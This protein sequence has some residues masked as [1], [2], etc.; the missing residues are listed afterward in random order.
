MTHAPL[1]TIALSRLFELAARALHSAGHAQGLYPAQWTA[2]RYLADAEPS[3]RT[4]SALARFQQIAIGPV[5]RTVRTLIAKGY[6]VKAGPAGHHR[7][8]RLDLTEAGYALLP[9]DPLRQI[10]TA[11]EALT[12]DQKVEVARLLNDIISRLQVE[13]GAAPIDGADEAASL[14]SDPDA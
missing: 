6:V 10:D 5:T 13:A 1:T 14:T 9:L 3:A 11:L 2:L 7:S 12:A 4:S 8:D